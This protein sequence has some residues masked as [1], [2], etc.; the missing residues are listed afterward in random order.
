MS[1]DHT[2]KRR[3]V[4]VG[5]AAAAAAG[6]I[7]TVGTATPA[8]AAAGP[9]DFDPAPLWRTAKNRGLAYGTAWATW[10]DDSELITLQ[11]RE[12]AILLTQDDL[13]W[14]VLKPNPKAKLDFSYGDQ[15]YALAEKEKQLV[16]GAH[17]VWDE[18]FGDGWS[19]DDL[20]GLNRRQ[21]SDLLYGVIRAEVKHYKGRTSAWITANEVTDP[22]GVNGFRTN[23]PWYNTIGQSYIAEAFH[24]AHD[25]DPDAELLINEFG[26]ETT[27]KYGDEP[28]KR[29]RAFLEVVDT[30]LSQ[31]V[32]VHAVGIQAH[33]LA[34]QFADRF[35]EQAYRH[36][37]TEIADR[38][39]HI[40]ITEMDVQD[41][42]LPANPAV[43]DPA[44]ADV[45]RRY[46][47]VTLDEP[48]V[49]AVLTFGLTDK[50]SWLNE[51][52]PRH[53]GANRRPLPFDNK[54]HRKPA[55]WA[56]HQSLLQAPYRKPLWSLPRG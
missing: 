51:D 48:A 12:A 49:K 18:G 45:Y 37:L 29:R 22:E 36:F 47:D 25:T 19:D 28:W 17:L 4:L 8:S 34:Y 52:Y 55:Y 44:V 6:A 56:L 3:S 41:G 5:A 15:F 46:L 7:G 14:Y 2:I 35:K 20:W 30:L 42:G 16:L 23:V 13:L 9:L 31:G 24:L 10:M 40:M 21:A 43:R 32:P 39:L 1:E 26:F 33:L 53:D 38:G 50:Y 27:N 54:Y 11:D